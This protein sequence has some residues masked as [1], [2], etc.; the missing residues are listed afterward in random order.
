MKKEK[1]LNT[2]NHLEKVQKWQEILQTIK[3]GQINLINRE[4][5]ALLV[6]DMQKIFGLKSSHAYVPSFP[7]IVPI[8]QKLISFFMKNKSKIYLTRHITNNIDNDPMVRWWKN[9][10]L[11]E[12]DESNIIDEI[13]QDMCTV[14][15][16]NQYSAFYNTNLLR[17]LESNHI[18][19]LIISGVMTHLCCETTIRDA[20]MKGFNIILVMDGTASYTED[21]H[22]GSMKSITHGFGQCLS[23]DDLIKKNIR[24]TNE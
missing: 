1:Y 18:E 2:E 5:M 12:A 13:P 11:E 15:K 4:K 22:L 19:T 16:K 20:F 6:L 23:A 14:I 17:E 10:I 9:P 8:I 7:T 3:K 21:L 24:L